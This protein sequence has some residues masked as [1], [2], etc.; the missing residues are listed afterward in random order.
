MTLKSSFLFAY[1]LVFPRTAIRSSAR[2]SV[3]GAMICIGISLIPL[4]VVLSVADGMI[5]GM[6]QRIIGLS[7]SDLESFV[8]RTCLY[9]ESKE[10]LENYSKLFL[11]IPGVTG[12]FPQIESDGL[13]AGKNYRTGARIRAINPSTFQENQDFASLFEIIDGDISSF[14]KT[15]KSAV[16]GQKMAEQLS[17]K[18][19]DTFRLITTKHT[20]KGGISPQ[21]SV[22]KVSAIV[23]SGYQ[24]LDALWIFIPLE[25]G[26]SVIPRQSAN[27]CVMIKT[28]DPFS[29]KLDEIHKKCGEICSGSGLVYSWKELN[30]GQFE[31]FSSTKVLLVFIM[32]L[33]VLVAA[34][35]I[36]SAIVMLVME[37]R[38]EIAILKSIGG[39]NKGIT[40]AFLITG[41]I[42]GFCGILMG[43]PVGIILSLN[44]NGL[45]SL[46]EMIMNFFA[47][48][49]F[50]AGGGSAAA[51]SHVHLLDPAYY[52]TSI[53]ISIPGVELAVICASVLVL[54]LVV[55]VV[56]A[57]NA[58][59]EKPLDIFRKA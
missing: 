16:V 32:L 33:I 21:V 57:M 47:K 10:E 53:P 23:S 41:V 24:E 9:S 7:T 43:L 11:N 2:R 29:R 6:T 13:A 49:S 58:G 59:K 38:K 17:L 56:P 34:V 44:A 51:F 54:S 25:T 39:S 31:N 26:F 50:I 55:S 14:G 48:L 45:I 19:G 20:A 30:A 36:S 22:F 18:S 46:M 52:L 4:I 37:R 42:C 15:A 27:F 12:V 35:N 28:E 5:G 3:L 1:R 8:S 40:V